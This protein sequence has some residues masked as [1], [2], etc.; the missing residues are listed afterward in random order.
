VSLL[1]RVKAANKAGPPEHSVLF[2]V[3]ATGALAVAIA[4][5]AAEGELSPALAAGS[6]AAVVAGNVFSYRR[7]TRPLP[8]LKVVLAVVAVVAFWRFYVAIAGARGVT[9]LG[10][11]EG[12]LALLFTWIQVTHSFDVPSR[13][14][15][16]FSLAGSLTLMAVAAA[17]AIDMTFGLYVIAWAACTV[18]GLV[19]MWGSMSG[20]GRPRLRTLV[21][22]SAAL[23]VVALVCLLAL[24]APSVSNKLVFPSSIG[25]GVSIPSPAGLEGNARGAGLPVQAGSASGRVGVGGF[26]GFAGPLDTAVRASLGNQLVLRVRATRPTFWVAE[27]FD[28]WDGRSWTEVVAKAK[29]QWHLLSFGPPFDLGPEAG[30]GA[31]APDIQTFYL[32]QPGPNLVFHAE[33]TSQVW[34]PARHLFV[35]RDGNIRSGTTMG[36]GSIYTVVSSVSPATP[37]Q[38]AASVGDTLGPDDQAR[39]TQLPHPYPRVAALA[40]R[41]TAHAPNTLAKVLALERWMSIHTRYSTDIPPLDEFLFGHRRGFCEQISTSLAVMLR[42]LGVPTREATGYVPGPYNPITDLYDVQAKDAHAWVQV[43]FPGFGWQSFDPT[44]LVANA[45]PSPATTLVH[46]ALGVLRRVPAVPTVLGAAAV[47]VVLVAWR[48]RSSAPATPGAAVSAALERAAR[49]AGLEPSAS[50]SLARLAGRID[51]HAP[52]PDQRPGA[53]AIAAAAEESAF[54][55][56]ELAGAVADRLVRD[57]RA[58]ARRVP[59]AKRRRGGPAQPDLDAA[60]AS[61]NETP[62]ASRAR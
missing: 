42:T 36:T 39:F 15:I 18:V 2:R 46:E 41:I 37:A 58:L 33:T 1:Q 20:A 38:L 32:V 4:A 48:R 47:A 7:R 54:G 52:P 8:W 50:E 27:T 19:A 28:Q 30:G 45:N 61:S 17:Q 14:D 51:A 60:N 5:C 31:G 34:F 43:W 22:G 49:R 11:V 25:G 23:V 44:A 12:P 57:A 29:T 40:A 53:R 3:A 9:N 16:A 62:E 6:I 59:R 10:A 24:P 21:A 13:R 56:R 55:G 26:L 35:D